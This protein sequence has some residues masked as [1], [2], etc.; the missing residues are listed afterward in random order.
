MDRNFI[1]RMEAGTMT[2]KTNP[3]NILPKEISPALSATVR[4]N[5]V[6]LNQSFASLMELTREQPQ[7]GI[8]IPVDLPRRP[9][10]PDG[11]GQIINIG[12]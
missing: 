4:K 12:I 5:P 1:P 11:T 6:L 10:L 2:D 9:T 8:P 7:F 3:F